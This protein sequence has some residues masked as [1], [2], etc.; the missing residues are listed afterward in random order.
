[1][2]RRHRLLGGGGGDVAPSVG[3]AVDVDIDGEGGLAEADGQG[4]VG[5]L[6]AD[7]PECGQALE[8]LGDATAVVLDNPP[9]QGEDVASLDVGEATP[10]SR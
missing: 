4:E 6:G 3:D 8:C 7:A 5:D 1:M 10:A 2:E 9:R